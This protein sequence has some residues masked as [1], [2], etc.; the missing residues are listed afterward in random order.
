M[1]EGEVI[2]LDYIPGKGTAVIIK[3][4]TKGVIDGHDFNQALMRIWLGDEPVGEKLKQNL[5]GGE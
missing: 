4:Q 3:G 2:H 1:K 5:L